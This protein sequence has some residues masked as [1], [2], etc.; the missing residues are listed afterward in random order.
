MQDMNFGLEWSPLN[1]LTVD[2]SYQYSMRSSN[3]DT[4]N[5]TDNTVM[6]SVGYKF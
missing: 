6:T 2:L 1:R 5:F 3:F 4:Y